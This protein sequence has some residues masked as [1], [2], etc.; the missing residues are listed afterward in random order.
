MGMFEFLIQMIQTNSSIFFISSLQKLSEHDTELDIFKNE[1]LLF[2]LPKSFPPSYPFTEDSLDSK[3]MKT[4]CPS[5]CD[6]IVFTKKAQDLIKLNVSN[7]IEKRF[8]IEI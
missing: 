8:K 2:E 3:Y 4:R 7:L 1:N 5:W 6:R